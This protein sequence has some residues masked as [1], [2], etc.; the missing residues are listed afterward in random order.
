MLSYLISLNESG[1]LTEKELVAEAASMLEA[2][3]VNTAHQTGLVV[4]TLLRNRQIWKTSD[5][6]P[7]VDSRC[8]G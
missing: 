4:W 6:G 2:S 5:P 1:K 7:L 8:R 3:S